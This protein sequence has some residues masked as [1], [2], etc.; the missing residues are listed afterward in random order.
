MA[1]LAGGSGKRAGGNIPKQLLQVAGKAVIEHAVEAFEHVLR[2]DEIVIVSREKEMPLI[3]D[4]ASRAG[5]SKVSRIVRGGPTRLASSM[6]AIRLLYDPRTRLLIHDAARPL[7]SR[8]VIN[9]VI[10]ALEEHDAVTAAIA[11]TDTIFRVAGDN[12]V[13]VPDRSSLA[14]AQTP[15]GFRLAT[16]RAAVELALLDPFFA[17]TD[18]CGTVRHYLPGT[19]VYLVPGDEQNMK[20][21]SPADLPLLERLLE[22]KQA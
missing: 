17:Q 1:L 3:A 21:T 6:E 13:E 15:Q 18:D 11:V 9:A 16:I 20:F 22:K 14:R 7:V 8:R 5:W 2:V 19:P 4:L 10:D 12:V